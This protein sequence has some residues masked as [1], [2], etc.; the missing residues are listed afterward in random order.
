MSETKRVV[1]KAGSVIRT[2][3]SS[4]GDTRGVASAK[5]QRVEPRIAR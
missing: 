1:V 4:L 5:K 3:F 2:D